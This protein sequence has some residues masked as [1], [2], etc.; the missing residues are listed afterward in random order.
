[1][2]TLKDYLYWMQPLLLAGLGYTFMKRIYVGKGNQAIADATSVDL[3]NFNNGLKYWQDIAD[4]FKLQI[5]QLLP[6]LDKL[7]NENRGLQDQIDNLND[8]LT[9]ALNDKISLR[10]EIDNL[11]KIVKGLQ[12][13]NTRLNKIIIG[14]NSHNLN[15]ETNDTTL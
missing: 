4:K 13:E 9:H 8:R 6:E 5:D 3:S 1:M 7:R 12:S 2:E 11:N 14:L 10:G 15:I